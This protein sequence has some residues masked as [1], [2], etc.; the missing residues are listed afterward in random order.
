MD[1]TW[2]NNAVIYGINLSTFQDGNGD[3]VGDF[4]GL[5]SRL[6][7]LADLGINC[8]WL[9][10]F[11]VSP[12]RD[13]GYD[14]SDYYNIDPRYGTL[15]DFR[16]F[17]A[18]ATNLGIKVIIELVVHHT[19]DQHPWFQAARSDRGSRY[20][21]YYIWSDKL[22]AGPPE[23]SF[24][25]EVESGVWR[26]D[27]VAKAYFH[28]G[29]YHFQ[30]DLNFANARVRNEVLAICDFWLSFGISG[31]R[32][33]AAPLI[34]GRKGLPHTEVINPGQFWQKIRQFINRR[35]PGAFVLA[36][37]DMAIAKI[38]EYVID[39][40]GVHTLLNFWLNQ[41]LH[42]ALATQNTDPLA[43]TLA[44]LPVPPKGTKYVNFL[45]NLDELN[46][47]LHVGQLDPS[48]QNEIY[49]H[50]GPSKS[51]Q[52]YGRGIRRRLAPM[53]EGD[54]ARLAQA[55][56]LL[57]AMPGIP[58]FV[59]GDELGMGENLDLAERDSVRTPMQ[60]SDQVNGGF[61]S[62]LTGPLHHRLVHDPRYHYK[63]LN[64]AAQASD[65]ASLL[66]F[67]KRLIALR[68]SQPLIGTEWFAPVKT[69][70]S[71]VL[72]LTYV[73]SHRLIILHNLS[74]AATD[75][76]LPKLAHGRWTEIFSDNPYPPP[77]GATVK[78][79]RYG[80]RWFSNE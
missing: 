25:P 48:Q 66:N 29:F 62:S 19:S 72:G 75:V 53:L 58:L 78:L 4:I 52:V 6:S 59:Y 36:E 8:V 47:K 67:V 49:Q 61:T 42:Y 63:N 43:A 21:D 41:T 80:F 73:D 3:G 5:T 56:S 74:P 76:H 27:P 14:V 45:R 46:V 65:P 60:W 18:Q 69:G 26:Y 39:G 23:E 16:D 33:D 22:P 7:Y 12:H 64:A 71:H 77:D 28:H 2:L 40:T 70:H 1:Q 11:F 55:F 10:P 54:R 15:D 31:F 30:P 32:L 20:H 17:V 79:G 51:M 37:A 44:E 50:L 24:F 13:N 68:K 38:N 57:F 34:I 9:L 35:H